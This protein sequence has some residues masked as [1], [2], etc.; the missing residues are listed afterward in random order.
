[1]NQFQFIDVHPYITE[2]E[3][4]SALR[5][6]QV[7]KTTKC[8]WFILCSVLNTFSHLLT[9]MP[10]MFRTDTETVKNELCYFFL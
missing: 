9:L 1:M 4:S 10:T 2:E 3:K 6:S 8:E 7:F 5:L